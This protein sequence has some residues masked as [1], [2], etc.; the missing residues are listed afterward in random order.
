MQHLSQILKLL[1]RI[2]LLFLHLFQLLLEFRRFLEV[3]LSLSLGDPLFQ[4]FLLLLLLIRHFAQ[5][6]RQLFELFFHR[7]LLFGGECFVSQLLCE[8]TQLL[9][10][11]FKVAIFHG[12]NQFVCGALFDVVQLRK[13]LLHLFRITE[14]FGARFQLV[15]E[16]VEFDK[17]F[18]L[19]HFSIGIQFRGL[20]LQRFEKL[21]SFFQA[22]LFRDLE[23]LKEFF[24]QIF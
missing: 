2:A 12:L 16:I 13:S 24:F 22:G 3:S 23:L 15:L 5:L 10:C 7:L 19:A 1:R 9:V 6:L 11:L 4:C 8:F 21:R 17:S 14:F 20:F 18:L